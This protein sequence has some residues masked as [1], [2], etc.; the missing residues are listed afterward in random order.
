[1]HF[2]DADADITNNRIH[3]PTVYLINQN[4]LKK[5]YQDHFK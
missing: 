5:R 2:V 4:Y 3:I 1:M